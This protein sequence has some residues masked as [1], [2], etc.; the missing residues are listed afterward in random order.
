MS[1]YY[2]NNGIRTQ[3]GG[4]ISQT[5]LDR[6]ESLE[7][8]ISSIEPQ[9]EILAGL[10]QGKL[11]ADKVTNATTVT[12]PGYAADARQ[13]NPA[14]GGSLASQIKNLNGVYVV[15]KYLVS[16][17]LFSGSNSHRWEDIDPFSYVLPQRSV[18]IMT[19]DFSYSANGDGWIEVFVSG[20]YYRFNQ[21]GTENTRIQLSRSFI[22]DANTKMA[23]S[24][25]IPV[26][27]QITI[28]GS[29]DV[30]YSHVEYVVFPLE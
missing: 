25:G 3:I 9:L 10:L 19:A 7:T 5:T 2:Q 17:I 6:I 21:K 1:I 12:Q 27:A 15:P 14:V 16:D 24:I 20:S 11:D 18:V 13:L 28:H 4:G 30:R 29:P 22:S 26:G 8:K 23:I